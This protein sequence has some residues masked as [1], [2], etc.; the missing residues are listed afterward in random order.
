MKDLTHMSPT[1]YFRILWRRKWYALAIFLIISGAIGIFS[2]STPSV[3]RSGSTVLVESALIPQ[4]YVRATDR[5]SLED[6]IASIRAQVQSRTFLEKIIQEL[7]MYGY[8]K[9]K[10]FSV[11]AAVA[12]IDSNI[13]VTNTSKNIFTISYSAQDPQ[14]A[15]KITKRI[16]ESLIES[17]N[18]SRKS[19]AVEADD[20]LEKQLS[21]AVQDLSAQEEKIK[22]FKTD[23]LGGLPEQAEANMRAISGLNVQLSAIENALQQARDKQKLL[24]FRLREQ[25]R[26]SALGSS[27]LN[28]PTM[29]SSEESNSSNKA[30]SGKG[31]KSSN[32]LLEVKEAE[33]ASLSAKYTSSHPDVIRA[34]REVSE[35]RKQLTAEA[36]NS[37]T[38]Q[39]GAPTEEKG[40]MPAFEQNAAAQSLNT[41]LDAESA[42]M[43]METE[44]AKNEISKKE[45]ER[46]AILG[47]IKTYQN[48][49]NL[50]PALD[51]EFTGLSREH[52]AL[53]QQY[54]NLQ[55]KKFQ[56]QMA[57][58]L[59]TDRNNDKY[60][61]IDEANLPET[62][63]FPDRLHIAL[64]GLGAG[65]LVGIGV[66]FGRE[67][68]DPS[69]SDEH[70][71]AAVLNLPVLVTFSEITEKNQRKLIGL[72]KTQKSA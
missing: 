25:K 65:L 40:A 72:P 22:K 41:M 14:D 64:M 34:S 44:S 10:E 58:N 30:K 46:D 26:F 3:Y 18:R 19:K 23:H 15:Q 52:E 6:Q 35:L 38:K 54:S 60:R 59:E 61:I 29:P 39:D 67:L 4:D 42:E 33:L 57:A 62:P 66:A 32:A 12:A 49:L 8:G 28:S 51:Q 1:D 50:V 37:F 7:Q 13:K 27:V 45:K 63:V 5:S 55:S 48:R 31:A 17:N 2:L 71:V 24:D 43:K 9:N 53:R 47:Q 68:L 11:D 36:A 21:K 16:V 56:S 70:E 20:F 69:L